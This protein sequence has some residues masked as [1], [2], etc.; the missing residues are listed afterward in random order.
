[1]LLQEGADAEFLTAGSSNGTA[2]FPARYHTK[3]ASNSFDAASS[4][5]WLWP[6]FVEA[7]VAGRIA[8]IVTILRTRD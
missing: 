8:R 1:M 4:R 6:L 3:M 7:A 5:I 2:L